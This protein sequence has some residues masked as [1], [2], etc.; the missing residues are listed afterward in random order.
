M[1][2]RQVNPSPRAKKMR[3]LT[4]TPDTRAR[5]KRGARLAGDLP[6]ARTGLNNSSAAS[7]SEIDPDKPLTDKMK[8][9]VQH[10]AKGDSIPSATLRAGYSDDGLGYRLARQPNILALYHAEK[11]KYEEAG[12]MTREKV[13]EGLIEAVEM[14]KLMSEPASMIAGW[15]EVGKMCGY[16]APVEHKMKVDV[17]GSIVVDRLNGMSDAE[18]LKLITSGGA[19]AL[20]HDPDRI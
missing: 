19:P 10:W 1:T 7:A 12:Q 3:D 18:L 20:S 11:A 6:A 14:A 16:Y 5:R 9:F 2:A 13:M 17:S 4:P 15:R 8:A